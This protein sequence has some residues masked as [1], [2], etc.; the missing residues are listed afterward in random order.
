MGFSFFFFWELKLI[1]SP[2]V[3]QTQ[4]S[5]PTV[6]AFPF[7]QSSLGTL[8]PNSRLVHSK[9]NDVKISRDNVLDQWEWISLPYAEHVEKLLLELNSRQAVDDKVDRGV[10][11]NEE[12]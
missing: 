4:T 8:C 12:P 9:Y 3:R 7:L 5:T 11:D 2:E 10:H 1:K 6:V